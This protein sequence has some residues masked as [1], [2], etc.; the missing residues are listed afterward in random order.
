MT[1]DDPDE[2]LKWLN[3]ESRGFNGPYTDPL[4][5][6]DPYPHQGY[7]KPSLLMEYPP[8]PRRF[9]GDLL[10]WV[11]IVIM[12]LSGG[13][14]VTMFMAFPFNLVV[15]AIV[16]FP[17]LA[18]FGLGHWLRRPQPTPPEHAGEIFE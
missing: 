14:T 17:A 11:G 13:C 12:V 18:L 15:G 9:I 4:P 8:Q 1:A 6:R 10:F 7:E 3:Q 16:F 5:Q 2:K